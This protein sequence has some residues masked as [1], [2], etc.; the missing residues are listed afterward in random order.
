MFIIVFD[1][2]A[3]FFFHCERIIVLCIHIN[4]YTYNTTITD[5]IEHLVQDRIIL[6]KKIHALCFIRKCFYFVTISYCAFN[7]HFVNILNKVVILTILVF[8]FYMNKKEILSKF[9]NTTFASY[10]SDNFEMFCDNAALS[11]Q[12]HIE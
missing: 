4:I 11:M 7:L 5:N 1:T 9:F 10:T 3:E 12:K 2:R 6:Y 8:R